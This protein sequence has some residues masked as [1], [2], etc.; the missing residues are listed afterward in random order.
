MPSIATIVPSLLG[1]G[2]TGAAATAVA[3]KAKKSAEDKKSCFKMPF[4]H[5]SVRMRFDNPVHLFPLHWD[6]YRVRFIGPLLVPA[7][8]AWDPSRREQLK[9]VDQ[10]AWFKI[11]LLDKQPPTDCRPIKTERHAL[12]VVSKDKVAFILIPVIHFQVIDIVKKQLGTSKWDDYLYEG[13][14]QLV[15]THARRLKHQQIIN[16]LLE[17]R[18]IDEA[19]VIGEAVGI[20]V[21][22]VGFKWMT[23]TAYGEVLAGS[24]AM[25]EGSARA[26]NKAF[27][28]LSSDVKDANPAIVASLLRPPMV[29]TSVGGPETLA[30]PEESG[31]GADVLDFP[32]PAAA[33]GQ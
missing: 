20:R 8:V 12:R 15:T 32:T 30:S 3:K 33:Q 16:G 2:T 23:L 18:I 27:A 22:E 7:P 11:F 17:K 14:V 25:A 19:R 6:R 4:G 21:D 9:I 13:I 29:T 26:L 31:R 5:K 28:A 1:V 10:G 24:E